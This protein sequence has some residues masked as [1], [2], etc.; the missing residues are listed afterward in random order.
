MLGS[1]LTRRLIDAG[2]RVTVASRTGRSHTWVGLVDPERVDSRLGDLRDAAFARSC[3]RGQEVVFHCASRIAGLAY[4]QHHPGEMMTYNTILDLQVLEAAAHCGV[5]LYFYPSGALVYDEDVAVP[6]S[7]SASTRG[8]PVSACKGAAIAKRAAEMAIQLV[9]EESEMRAVVARFSNIYGPGDDFGG[10][11]AH[12]IGNM[13]RAIAHDEPPEIW[14]DGSQLRS[15]L[16]VDDAV[17]AALQLAEVH[18]D[19]GPVNVGGQTES[20]V[21]AIAETLVQISGK[22]LTPVCRPTG[23]PLGLRRKLLDNGKLRALTAFAE[24]TSLRAGLETTYR[25]YVWTCGLA[26]S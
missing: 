23:R 3:A 18:G 14:G 11:R 19:H 6:V 24:T 20:T 22:T 26:R 10:E 2:A 1:H 13:I 8:E 12:L 17:T 9:A 7:E 5:Q 21:R 4:N 16:Y 25:W 15:F